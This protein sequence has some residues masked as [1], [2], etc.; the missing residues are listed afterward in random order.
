MM[1]TMSSYDAFSPAVR[2]WFDASFAAPTDIQR[3]AWDAIASGDHALVIAPTGSGKTLAAFLHALDA[4][5]CEQPRDK[6][7]VL[8][9][10]PLKALAADIEANLRAPLRGIELAAQRLGTPYHPPRVGVR[11]GD[12]AAAERRRQVTHPPDILITTPESLFLLLSSQAATTLDGVQFVIV[13]EVHALAGTKRGAHLALSLER[14]AAVVGEDP[15]R[16]GLSA[17]VR[18]AE[19]VAAFLGGDRNVSIINPPGHKRWDLSV[20]LAVPDLTEL[21]EDA[22]SVWP[23]VERDVLEAIDQHRS[24]ICFVNSRRVAERL[25]ARLNELHAQRT[26]ALLT[27]ETQP[28]QVSAQSGKTLAW[29]ADFVPIAQA[30]H[31]SVSHG[32]RAQIEDDLKAGRLRC[33]VATSSLE[34]GID[35]GAVDLVL[36]VD[37]PPSV[38]SGLQRLGRAGH[39]VGAVSRGCLLPTH[40]HSVLEAAVVAERMIAG[41]IEEVRVVHRPLD[42]LAQHIVSA[43][44][45][46]VVSVDDLFATVRRAAPYATLSRALLDSVLDMLAGRYPSEEFA[47]LRPRIVW[48]RLADTITARPGAKRLVTT[49]GGT[50]PDRGLFGVFL[51]GDNNASGRHQA[52]RRVGE[53]DEEMVYESRVGDVIALGT[54]SWQIADITPNQVLVTPAPGRAGRLPFWHGDAPSRPAELGRALGTLVS[55]ASPAILG[56]LDDNARRNALGYLADQRAACGD[57]PDANTIVVERFRDELGDWRLCVHSLFGLPVNAPWALA[58]ERAARDR[59]GI[60]ARATAT[61]DGIVL[62]LPDTDDAPPGA[63]LFSFDAESLD[64][65]V[66]AEVTGSALFAA[67]FR[68]CAARALL[69]PRRDPGRR[70]PL[71]QQ[72]MRS[73]QLLGVAASYPDFP[74]MLETMRECLNDVF[75][76]PELRRLHADLAARRVRLV[77]VETPGPSPFARHLL[78]GYLAEFIYDG[79]QPLAERRLA[80]LSLDTALLADL[81]GKD[82]L[83]EVFSPE[84]IASVD[85]SLRPDLDSLSSP[86]RLWDAVRTVGPIATERLGSPALAWLDALVAERRIAPVRLANLD[87]VVISDDVALL[88]DGLG[89]PVPPGWPEL[90]H[91]PPSDALTRLVVRHLRTHAVSTR[92]EL[93]ERF[94]LAPTSIEVVMQ[95]LVESGQVMRGRFHS[96]LAEADQYVHRSVLDL[97]KRRSLAALRREIEPVPQAHYAR[98]LTHWHELHRPGSGIEGLLTAIETLAGY[99]VPASMLDGIVL[100]NRVRDYSPAILDELI[101]TGEVIFTGGGAIGRGDGYVRLWPADLVVRCDAPGLSDTAITLLA[102]LQGGGAWRID[103]I[104]ERHPDWARDQLKDALWD[105]FWAG[106]VSADTL[107]PVRALT[108]RGAVK[109]APTPRPGR[110]FIRQPRLVDRQTSGR[111]SAVASGASTSEIFTTELTIWLNRY[112]VLTRGSILTE[113]GDH[114]FADA[115]RALNLLESRGTVRRGYFVDG[116]GGSQFALPGAV[117]ALRSTAADEPLV[118]AATDPANAWGAAL[119][120]P[121]SDGHRPTRKA[122]AFVVLIDGRPIWFAERGLSTLMRFSDASDDDLDLGL[123]ALADV[124]RRAQV[125]GIKVTRIGMVP[126]LDAR[127]HHERLVRAG[128]VQ[129]PSGFRLRT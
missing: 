4:V 127:E 11:T 22:S 26:G 128:F 98:F 114:S 20:S 117:D 12:T 110:R 86:E 94:G 126:A 69:L 59:Y 37:A 93:A 19:R 51:V 6:V 72:R 97:L 106:Q 99:P 71:W 39:Q 65:M 129:H 27:S 90:G 45:D 33:V 10:S 35:M 21:P 52:G 63:E 123:S 78:F 53:L 1:G 38:A 31:G 119:P 68:E 25:T 23:F 104:A 8:Y 108:S 2:A 18:P 15:Q 101:S 112:G 55:N 82:A 73:A 88:R 81:L 30:H 5:G 29:L 95:P 70:T 120:W 121:P 44:L 24:T 32:R 56:L 79:D 61:N 50:I 89:V 40:R 13:D 107:S 85:A 74:I 83:A 96:E 113:P 16:I 42:V 105:L 100:P 9:I 60:E 62:R 46:R 84:V 76:L 66:G 103:E 92:R 64:E 67:R 14:L 91:T 116:L 28:S 122:G 43:C 102:T 48:D 118:L 17:T 7:R 115:Y 124:L 54:T 58:I 109:R 80:A 111:W 49:S 75:D 125:P 57:L 41:D 3:A 77:E 87:Q 34:L 36:Q 47:E